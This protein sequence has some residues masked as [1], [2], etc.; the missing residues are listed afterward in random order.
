MN[1]K[2]IFIRP[3]QTTDEEEVIELWRRCNLIVPWN[4]S[5][6]DI[7]LKLQVQPQLFLVGT[8]DDRIV[9]TVMAGYEG[10]RGWIKYL[11]VAPDLQR[12]GISRR[13]MEAAE[14]ELKKLSCPK[15]NLQLRSSNRAVIAF[16]ESIGFSV[17]DVISMGKRLQ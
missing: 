8:I 11:A 1:V 16:Y 15:I 10:H 5:K 14:V 4:D 12:Q 17:D 2:E 13:M 6:R 7:M 3:Y 9:A